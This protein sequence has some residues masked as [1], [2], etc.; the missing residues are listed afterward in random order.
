MWLQIRKK[1]EGNGLSASKIQPINERNSSGAAAER[2]R[3]S[4][5]SQSQFSSVRNMAIRFSCNSGISEGADHPAGALAILRCLGI[6]V[7]WLCISCGLLGL[8][9]LPPGR[10]GLY[11]AVVVWGFVVIAASIV[12]GMWFRIGR[13]R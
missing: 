7:V 8:L 5:G 2:I 1:R 11:R 9:Y 6:T 13:A 3:R 12:C 4:A 10:F